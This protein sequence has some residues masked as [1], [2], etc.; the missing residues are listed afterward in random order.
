MTRA[1]PPMA[2]P[3]P[4]SAFVEKRALRAA[5]TD[6][7]PTAEDAIHTPTRR[8]SYTNRSVLRGYEQP[9]PWLVRQYPVARAAA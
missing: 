3:Q 7:L 8:S 6:D 4:A 2:T 1:S 9:K 5:H